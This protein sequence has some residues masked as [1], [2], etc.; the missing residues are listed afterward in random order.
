VDCPPISKIETPAETF[1][2]NI[3]RI[4]EVPAVWRPPSEKESGVKLRIPMTLVGRVSNEEDM[5][6]MPGERKVKGESGIVGLGSCT[7]LAKK[8]GDT[9]G[10]GRTA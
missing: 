10:G 2:S 8:L 9:K 6:G 4:E 3:D 1:F 7:S 5:G